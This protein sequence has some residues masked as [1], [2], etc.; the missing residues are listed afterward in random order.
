MA[1]L[2]RRQHGRITRAQLVALG[3]PSSTVGAWSRSGYLT[4]VLPRVYA[5]GHTAPSREADLWAAVLYAGPGA[6]LSHASAA[7]HRRLIIHPPRVI[8]VSTPRAKIRSIGGVILVHARRSPARDAHQGIPT[9]TSV[10]T[11]LDLAGSE[12][13]QLVRRALAVLDF[14]KELDLDALDAIA[15]RGRPGSLALR[16]ALAA[17]RPELAYTNGR[18]EEAFLHLCE[19]HGLPIPRF[20]VWMYGFPVD[21]YWPEHNLI[22]EVDGRDAHSSRAQLHRD[23]RKELTLRRHGHRVVRYD[24]PLVHSAADE[25]CADLRRQLAG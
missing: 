8:H 4:R 16:R 20:N 22:V 10:Q 2:V 7:H 11:V 17:H 3:V 9:T 25:V 18:L 1:Q 21:A 24:W 12:S 15:G 5:V 6:M 13:P 14:R 19:R 23:R